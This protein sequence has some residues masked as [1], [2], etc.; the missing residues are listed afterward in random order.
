MKRLIKVGLAT[1]GVCG[2]ILALLASAFVVRLVW[3]LMVGLTNNGG[4]M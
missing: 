4:G 3:K 2:F 1:F